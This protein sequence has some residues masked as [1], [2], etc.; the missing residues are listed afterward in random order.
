LVLAWLARRWSESARWLA[1]TLL[2]LHALAPF[3]GPYLRES[4]NISGSWLS[5]LPMGAIV[6]AIA[7]FFFY[8]ILVLL[9]ALRRAPTK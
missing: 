2:A 5:N 4:L 6:G 8:G 9:L 7:T 3:L 1:V